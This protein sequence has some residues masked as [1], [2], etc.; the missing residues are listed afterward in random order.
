MLLDPC[1]FCPSLLPCCCIYGPIFYALQLSHAKAGW[2]PMDKSS[3]PPIF[4]VPPLWWMLSSGHWCETKRCAHFM[5]NFHMSILILIHQN[6]LS[7][8][9]LPILLL[10]GCWPTSQAICRCTGVHVFSYLRLLV[11]PHQVDDQVYFT[12]RT[13]NIHSVACSLSI[14]WFILGRSCIYFVKYPLFCF[15]GAESTFPGG[16]CWV[17]TFLL[18]WVMRGDGIR[19]WREQVSSFMVF[20]NGETA[21]L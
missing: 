2:P 18:P 5:L 9:G 3:Y 13:L 10:Q 17:L 1:I 8:R 4:S 6:S 12:L 19:S 20:K 7:G 15:P 16:P 14:C 21:T 11:P